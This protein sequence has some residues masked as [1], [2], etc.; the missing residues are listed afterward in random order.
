M[1]VCKILHI[2]TTLCSGGAE[3]MLYKLITNWSDSK[4]QDCSFEHCIV[5]LTGPGIYG[6]KLKASGI[7]VYCLNMERSIFDLRKF[8]TLYS[9][10]RKYRPH[11]LQTW[12]YHSDLIGLASGGLARVPNIVW[13][14]RCSYMDFKHYSFGTRMIFA[15]LS[16]LSFVPDAVVVNSEAGKQFHIKK[17]YRPRLWEVIPNGFDTDIFKPDASAGSRLRQFLGIDSPVQ[18]IGM[19]ARFDP[20]KDHANFFAAARIVSDFYPDVR[21]V[22]VGRG[23]TEQ[24][25]E[26]MKMIRENSMNN[27]TYLLGERTDIQDIVPGFDICTLSSSFGEGF[28]N[29]LGEAMS[30]GVPCVATDVGDS[31]FII[32]DAG[33]VVPPGNAESLARAWLDMLLLSQQQRAELGRKAR[34]RVENNFSVLKAVNRYERLY[35]ELLSE[36]H[37]R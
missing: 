13:N 1:T 27:R 34:K 15:L 25:I 16:K 18:I 20:M 21:F 29:V 22:L 37:V 9:F 8:V 31:A 26:L 32:A 24:N 5:S 4:A 11:I 17:G 33:K 2:I 28:P 35:L 7:Q 12:L 14:V 23:I 36:R 6:P 19:V 3:A 10:I 30:C